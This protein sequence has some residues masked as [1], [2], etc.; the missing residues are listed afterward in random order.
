MGRGGEVVVFCS[1]FMC[2]NFKRGPHHVNM[3]C[4]PVGEGDC[5]RVMVS[6]SVDIFTFLSYII[7]CFL[8]TCVL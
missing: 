1:G 7:A 6:N 4:K 3:F 8:L 5:T 2:V